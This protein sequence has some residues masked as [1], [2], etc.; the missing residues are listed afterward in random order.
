LQLVFAADENVHY[1]EVNQAS[2]LKVLK[3]SVRR[4]SGQDLVIT[5]VLAG[6]DALPACPDANEGNWVEKV[7][8]TAQSLGIPMEV[9][10]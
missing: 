5:P 8:K 7:R 6:Q 3:E 10:E 1:H 4:L 2:A 9:E